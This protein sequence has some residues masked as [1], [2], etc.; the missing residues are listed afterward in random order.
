M[1]KWVPSFLLLVVTFPGLRKT[2]AVLVRGNREKTL[3]NHVVLLSLFNS[4]KTTVWGNLGNTMIVFLPV[5]EKAFIF[6][7]AFVRPVH[8]P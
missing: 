8:L 3:C 7:I 5:Q 6:Y 2:S 4:K 1:G